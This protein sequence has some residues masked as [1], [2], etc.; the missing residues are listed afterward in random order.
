MR[1][2]ALRW[3]IA[4]IAI[5]VVGLYIGLPAAFGIAAI[6]LLHGAGGSREAMRP[7][8]DMLRRHGYGVLALDQRGHGSS[9]GAT[10]RLGW[11]G[12]IDVGAAVDYLQDRGGVKAIGGLGWSMGGEVLLGAA[13]DYPAIKAIVAVGAWRRSTGELLALPSERPLVRNFTAR[14]MY[15]TVQLLSGD[16]PPKP[17]LDSMVAAG[18]TAF[19]LIA[20]GAKSLPRRRIPACSAAIPRSMNSACLPF[21]MSSFSLM[22]APLA[23]NPEL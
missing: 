19:L 20:G 16:R 11:Q 5:A 15:A 10:N 7:V 12:T 13:A 8:A 9:G 1:G 18:S 6:I 23:A 2:R 4:I 3:I 22:P 14:V 21:S 17:L